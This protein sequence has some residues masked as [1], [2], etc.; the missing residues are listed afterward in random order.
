MGCDKHN[1][2]VELLRAI[3]QGSLLNEAVTTATSYVS[4]NVTRTTEVLETTAMKERETNKPTI[5]DEINEY[6]RKEAPKDIE[7]PTVQGIAKR[8]GISED[9]L[10]HWLNHDIQFRE[11]LTRLKEFQTN[12][13]LNEGTE[14][15]YFIH[16]SGVQF[17]LDETWDR[18]YKPHN[19]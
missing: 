10:N 13:P 5:F 6:L 16:S 15:D 2:E 8:L 7:E 9:V 1:H 14:F 18:H 3:D 11:E 4:F 17:I 19:Q 12:D